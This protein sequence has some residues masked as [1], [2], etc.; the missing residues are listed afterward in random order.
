VRSP[1]TKMSGRRWNLSRVEN[2]PQH[3]LQAVNRGVVGVR[4]AVL[5]DGP[6]VFAARAG[7]FGSSR[8]FSTGSSRAYTASWWCRRRYS[9]ERGGVPEVSP[10]APSGDR[11]SLC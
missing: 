7:G 4:P 9:G 5:G 6:R 8:S 10:R 1:P 11:W 2:G 3:A